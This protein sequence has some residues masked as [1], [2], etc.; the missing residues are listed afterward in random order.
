MLQEAHAAVELKP[1][2]RGY[3]GS[4]SQVLVPGDYKSGLCEKLLEASPMSFQASA[5]GLQQGP[6]AGQG[7]ASG[8]THLT[9]GKRYCSGAIE[10]REEWEYV[11][12][13]T[14][15]LLS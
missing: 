10:T 4:H 9:G 5:R 7:S 15:Q 1:L 6:A 13:T 12:E 14:L 11:R 2:I 3:D 8:I